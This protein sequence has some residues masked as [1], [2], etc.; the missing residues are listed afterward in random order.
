ME[1][2][3]YYIINNIDNYKISEPLVLMSNNI[4]NTI[5]SQ[6]NMNYLLLIGFPNSITLSTNIDII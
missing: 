6:I 5:I 1:S 4:Y 2:L 3:E